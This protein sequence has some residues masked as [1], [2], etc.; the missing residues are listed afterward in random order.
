MKKSL[1]YRT[2]WPKK[3]FISL[4]LIVSIVVDLDR[5]RGESWTSIYLSGSVLALSCAT[6]DKLIWCLILDGLSNNFG[7]INQD[8]S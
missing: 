6:F 2:A 1:F 4:S 7:L 5:L 3:S 8:I